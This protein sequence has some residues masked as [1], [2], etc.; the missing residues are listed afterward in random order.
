MPEETTA[1]LRDPAEAKKDFKKTAFKVGLFM[2]L[3]FILRYAG[4][5]ILL[6]VDG[7]IGDSMPY[8][9]RYI[10]QLSI[11]AL[12]LQV[13]PAVIGAFMFG[14][15]GKGGTGLKAHYKVPKSNTRALGNFPAVYGTGAAV[16]LVTMIVL[17][18]IER[19]IDFTRKLNTVSPAFEGDI[20]SALFLFF[21]LVVIAPI[22]EEFVYRG[23]LMDA[24]KPYGNGF[25]I[26][27]TGIMFGLAHANFQQMFYTAVIGIC[28]GYI[29]NVTGSIF[30]TTILHMMVNSISGIMVLLLS[31]NGV[32]QFILRGNTDAVPDSDM[33]WLA[34]FGIFM[35]SVVILA[36]I[37]FIS[38]IMKIKQI[39]RY[40]VPKVFPELGNGR[41]ALILV[42]AVPSVIAILMIIDTVFGISAGLIGG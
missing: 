6:A 26:F 27:T 10:I 37:G 17:M 19:K 32:Q 22:F 35:V 7:A 29:A 5:Y 23:A 13:A 41:K 3:V 36:V 12:F 25:A 42:T 1:E 33:I 11:S 14:W 30:P 39:K 34:V 8:T 21:M 38:A 40:K 20:S 24:L 15:L 18:L 28:L 9:P 16:S 2:M 4:L 31:T